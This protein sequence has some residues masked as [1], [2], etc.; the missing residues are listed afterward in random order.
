[1][2]VKKNATGYNDEQQNKGQDRV[3]GTNSGDRDTI[4]PDGLSTAGM[5]V[6]GAR[7]FY[8]RAASPGD[9]QRDREED[10]P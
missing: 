9:I 2:A 3:R 6:V 7:R 8:E 4:A 5:A 1:M 10:H